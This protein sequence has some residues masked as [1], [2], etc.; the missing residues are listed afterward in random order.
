MKI[1][2]FSGLTKTGELILT[3]A[4]SFMDTLPND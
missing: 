1:F 3:L 2:C 4:T